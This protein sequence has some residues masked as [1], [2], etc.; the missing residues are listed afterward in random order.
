[1]DSA[2]GRIEIFP[3]PLALAHHIAEWMTQAALA[4]PGPFRV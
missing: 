4:A 1:M 2:I 3:D